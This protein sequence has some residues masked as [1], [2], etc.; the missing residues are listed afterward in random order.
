MRHLKRVP[1]I[2]TG[3]LQRGCFGP[4]RPHDSQQSG[5]DDERATACASPSAEGCR[6]KAEL[7][8]VHFNNGTEATRPAVVVVFLRGSRVVY[9]HVGSPKG[10]VTQDV[11]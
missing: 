4:E 1:A 10:K 2:G 11:D 7:V 8:D 5:V 3:S 9:Q 6:R